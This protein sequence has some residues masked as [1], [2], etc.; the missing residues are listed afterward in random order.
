MLPNDTTLIFLRDTETHI[1]YWDSKN[2][3][4]GPEERW[5]TPYLY[6][7]SDW[8]V[9]VSPDFRKVYLEGARI[10]TTREG[11]FYLNYDIIV[12]YRDTTNPMGYKPPRIL[13]FCLYADTQYIAGNYADRLEGYPNLTP[14]GKKMYLVATYDGQT[15]IYES[16]MLI[17]ENGDT[18]TNVENNSVNL[19]YSF[20]LYQSY[21]NPFN[22]STTIE[23]ALQ[24][25]GKVV[26]KIFDTVGRELKTL[27]NKNQR[28]GGYK[29]VWDGTDN[30]GDKVSSGIYFYRLEIDKATI[31]KKAVFIK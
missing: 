16:D 20:V 12:C 2:Q 21:P 10:D 9:Y 8:G 27:V 31:T 29:V 23:Y 18:V 1:S 3:T 13:N 14:D 6:F 17:D 24:K 11:R 28:S 22:P 30:K 19:L 26:L 25:E 4:W 5:P 7:Q 15:T